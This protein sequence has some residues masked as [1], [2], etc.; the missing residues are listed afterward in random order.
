MAQPIEEIQHL[1][2]ARWLRDREI[3]TGERL[4]DRGEHLPSKHG[5][6]DPGRQQKSMPHR[7]PLSP[8]GKATPRDE[9]VDVRMQHQGLTPRVQRGDDP[10]LCPEILRVRQ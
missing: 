3:L 4:A 2:R 8:G 5:H 10:G 9:T 1:L 6:H 7:D